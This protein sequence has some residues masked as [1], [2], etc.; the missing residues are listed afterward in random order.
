MIG[1]V[2]YEYLTMDVFWALPRMQLACLMQS[3]I[4]PENMKKFPAY[5]YINLS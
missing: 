3:G 1:T 4:P 5:E 2:L